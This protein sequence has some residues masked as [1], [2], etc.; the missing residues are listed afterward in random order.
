M[1]IVTCLIQKHL[2]RIRRRQVDS[3]LGQGPRTIQLL[4]WGAVN[5]SWYDVK[6]P[7][8]TAL[9]GPIND[10]WHGVGSKRCAEERE[11]SIDRPHLDSWYERIH[12]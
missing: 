2:C 7:K 6:S 5:D 10:S 9:I 12:S 1:T 4:K 8:A 3:L 11:R